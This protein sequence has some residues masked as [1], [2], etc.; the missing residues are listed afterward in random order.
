MNESK[1]QYM[2]SSKSC[3][4]F[5]KSER[6]NFEVGEV[7]AGTS[8]GISE[9]CLSGMILPGNT[10]I[11]LRTVWSEMFSNLRIV[12]ICATAYMLNW[13]CDEVLPL[14]MTDRLC[15]VPKNSIGMTFLITAQVNAM[16]YK[17][18]LEA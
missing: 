16:T 17:L 14:R 15:S 3:V 6:D 5:R 18:P 11:S 12:T 2:N 1:S 10:L 7:F 9:I 13:I 8:H 4:R